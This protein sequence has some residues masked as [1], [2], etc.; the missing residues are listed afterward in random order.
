MSSP[1]YDRDIYQLHVLLKFA[2]INAQPLALSRLRLMG[3]LMGNMSGKA[4]ES[5]SESWQ[6]LL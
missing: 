2:R 5:L 6:W 4:A 3:P 1:V